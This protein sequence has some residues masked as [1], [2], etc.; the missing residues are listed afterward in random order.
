MSK[1]G[2]GL[3]SFIMISRDNSLPSRVIYLS[4][5]LSF[6]P[7]IF[8]STTLIFLPFP[9]PLPHPLSLPCIPSFLSP[10]LPLLSLPTLPLALPSSSHPSSS[11]PHPPL[12]PVSS[13]SLPSPPTHLFPSVLFSSSPLLSPV[14]HFHS[15]LSS[16]SI[17]STDPPL[18]SLPSPPDPKLSCSVIVLSNARHHSSSK[19]ID[20]PMENARKLNKI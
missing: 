1:P 4:H 20:N 10:L 5:Y 18:A 17:V 12:S 6:H 13:P 7:V 2:I 19:A 16:S 14:H 8:S 9:S 11:L 3:P 15:R